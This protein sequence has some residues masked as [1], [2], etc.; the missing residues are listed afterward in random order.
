M[1]INSQ[2]P[3]SSPLLHSE[4]ELDSAPLT[5]GF[6]SLSKGKN[7]KLITKGEHREQQQDEAYLTP[8]PSSSL[9]DVTIAS[10]NCEA[11]DSMIKTNADSSPSKISRVVHDEIELVH[12]TKKSKPNPTSSI[13][14]SQPLNAKNFGNVMHIPLNGDKFKIGRSGLSCSFKL[15]SK[16]K[17][18]SRVHAEVQFDEKSQM[19]TLKC[20]GFNGLNITVPK[21]ISVEHLKDREYLIKISEAAEVKEAKGK[22]DQN[23]ST[24]EGSSKSR[25]LTRSSAFTNFYMLKDESI[26]MPLI[27]GTVLDFRGDLALLVYKKDPLNA[28]S[29]T[30]IATDDSKKRKLSTGDLLK[31]VEEKKLQFSTHPT[32]AELKNKKSLALSS[33]GARPIVKKNLA[34]TIIYKRASPAPTNENME[35]S[36]NQTVEKRASEIADSMVSKVKIESPKSTRAP[37]ADVTNEHQK[38]GAAVE[39]KPVDTTSKIVVKQEMPQLDLPLKSTT[40]EERSK[41]PEIRGDVPAEEQKKR[42]RSKKVKQTEEDILRSMPKEEVDA[43]LTTVPELDDIS[44]LVTNHIAY[45]RIL[46]T[47]FSSIREL[48]SIKKHNLT[49]LQLR[50]ILI[51]HIACIGVIFRQGK[52]AAGKPLD[53]EYY[54]VPEKDS[55]VH[56][57]QLVEELKGSSSHLRSCRKTHKQYFWKK[58]KL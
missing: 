32:L 28:A 56:R 30:F 26:K 1:N 4:N 12:S 48:N 37:L 52:D 2:F 50:C 43:V 54:Y 23:D 31:I 14:V 17:L 22:E 9:G 27:E 38:A 58:P 44:N 18:I 51:H 6:D 34:N 46:Q 21:L 33:S 41:S 11:N 10:D 7:F 24:T 5:D 19:I 45:S 53:E 40:R 57:V 8:D 39:K 36:A 25:I 55:D 29:K 15:N 42:G 13:D 35:K 47:P 3:P 16:N 20:L 49:K